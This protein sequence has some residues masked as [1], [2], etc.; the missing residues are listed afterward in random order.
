M[1]QRMPSALGSPRAVLAAAER[2]D[3][4]GHAIHVA[5]ALLWAFVQSITNAGEGIAWGML[6]GITILRVPKVHHQPWLG[7]ARQKQR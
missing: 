5:L 7:Y 4:R 6:L 1:E 2:A 3:P